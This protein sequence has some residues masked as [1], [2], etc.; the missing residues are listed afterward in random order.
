MQE[1]TARLSDGIIRHICTPYSAPPDV[2]SIL[3]CV[4]QAISVAMF[5]QQQH[6]NCY[7]SGRSLPWPTVYKLI[8]H[9]CE[10]IK[11]FVHRLQLDETL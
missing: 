10:L 9:G 4:M 11:L 6:D 7:Y 3:P 2:R 1:H 8:F 5:G